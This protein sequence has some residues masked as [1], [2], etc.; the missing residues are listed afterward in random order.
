MVRCRLPTN[1]GLSPL[2]PPRRPCLIPSIVSPE[3]NAE[4]VRGR[5]GLY[6]QDGCK[7]GAAKY[8]EMISNIATSARLFRVVSP[9]KGCVNGG[10]GGGGVNWGWCGGWGWREEGRVIDAPDV[11]GF[12][13][14]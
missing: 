7:K 8:P 6:G 2:S 1:S 13:S 14:T 9:R 10:G 11:P 4:T 5:R 12:G 3:L